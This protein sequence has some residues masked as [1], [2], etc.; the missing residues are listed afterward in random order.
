MKT[1][2]GLFVSTILMLNG[3]ATEKQQETSSNLA[4]IDLA[5]IDADY[6]KFYL[7]ASTAQETFEF[8]G[9]GSIDA[10]LN[11]GEYKIE[12]DYLDANNTT[13][14]SSRFCSEIY[15]TNNNTFEIAP[16]KNRIDLH[17]CEVDGT[18]L[19]DL[20]INPILVS[21]D[22]E[23]FSEDFSEGHGN[24]E[25]KNLSGLAKWQLS[26]FQGV[27]FA[28]A[29]AFGSDELV[30][31]WLISPAIDLAGIANPFFAFT[32]VI[33]YGTD[34]EKMTDMLQ[35]K[36]SADYDGDFATATWETFDIASS[37][38]ISEETF[39]KEKV[40]Q[41]FSLEGFEGQS[42]VIAFAYKVAADELIKPRW[43]IRSVVVAK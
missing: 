23:I 42:I 30:E 7:T 18:S 15:R 10:Q 13:L 43:Q 17:I 3:C 33:A 36:V 21:K 35:V 28:Q 41:R 20:Y 38:P 25:V 40:S 16:G 5:E 27:N 1:F 9:S 12:L 32:N 19:S 37:L 24:F 22:S 8:R 29:S 11:P 4:S 39:S 31:T 6:S 34:L 2:S 14:F 26:S